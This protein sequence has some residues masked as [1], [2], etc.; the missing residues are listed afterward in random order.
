VPQQDEDGLAGRIA[1]EAA[2][3]L[4]SRIADFRV[5]PGSAGPYDQWQLVDPRDYDL[6]VDEHELVYRRL[7]DGRLTVIELDTR[8][9]KPPTHE[10]LA[11]E[12]AR[13]QERVRARAQELR[14]QEKAARE[15]GQT[16]WK[17]GKEPKWVTDLLGPEGGEPGEPEA[18]PHA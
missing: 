14:G 8:A 13:V 3:W 7:S 15:N 6:A 5:P 10:Q 17:L 9:W 18:E 2:E 1:V 11:K 16:I 12:K 4:M